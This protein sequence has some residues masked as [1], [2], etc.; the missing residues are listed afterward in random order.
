[1][2]KQ[3]GEYETKYKAICLTHFLPEYNLVELEYFCCYWG[4]NWEIENK[5]RNRQRKGMGRQERRTEG[6]REGRRESEKERERLL[7]ALGN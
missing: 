2:H 5:R 3:T 7:A 1:M 4:T 6:A